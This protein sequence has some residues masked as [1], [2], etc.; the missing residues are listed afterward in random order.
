LQLVESSAFSL[1]LLRQFIKSFYFDYAG[2]TIKNTS[3]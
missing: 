1:F 3:G 2:K